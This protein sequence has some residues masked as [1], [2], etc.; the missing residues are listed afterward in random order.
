MPGEPATAAVP[1]IRERPIIFSS[2]SVRAI[3]AGRK[4]QTRR[5]VKNLRIRLRHQVS[6]DL[7]EICRPRLRIAEG[8]VCVA[9]MNQHGA[10][11]ARTP[12]G[13]LLGIRPDEFDFL[14]PYAD[15]FTYLRKHPSQPNL[16]AWEIRTLREYL[17]VRESWWKPPR[18]TP[19]MLREGADTWPPL[20]HD[21]DVAD[22]ADLR[23][24]GWRRMS[25]LHL[26][27]ADARLLLEVT[28]VRIQHVQD[29]TE[30]DAIAEGAVDIIQSR[31]GRGFDVDM[32]DWARWTKALNPNAGVGS[33]R[34]AFAALWERM[35]AAGAW[36]ANGWTW[37]ITFRRVS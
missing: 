20:Y 4:V 14:C 17:W 36:K 16:D 33:A 23:E 15:G 2:E 7:P 28:G 19:R 6:S 10:V 37:A 26:R 27:R 29:I 22:P 31:D 24:Q 12:E 18:I 13:R 21:A 34:G 5:P 35:H 30:E 11:S 3:L 32:R 9:E 8:A 1:A 25:P